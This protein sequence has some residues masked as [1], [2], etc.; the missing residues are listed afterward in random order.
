M[1]GRRA[2]LIQSVLIGALAKKSAMQALGLYNLMDDGGG[3]VTTD[4]GKTYPDPG[5]I[6]MVLLFGTPRDLKVLGSD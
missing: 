4:I 2:C 3:A 6:G 1:K 5:R